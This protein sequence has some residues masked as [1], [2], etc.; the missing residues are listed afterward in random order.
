MRPLRLPTLPSILVVSFAAGAAGCA[1][2]AEPPG[3]LD[4]IAFDSTCPDTGCG[5]N[6]SFVNGWAIGELH[7]GAPPWPPPA[8][9]YDEGLKQSN[10]ANDA[11]VRLLHLRKDG[12]FYR[13]HVEGHRLVGRN[14]AGVDAL[15]GPALEGSALAVKLPDGD[16]A[17][18]HLVEFRRDLP[19]WISPDPNPSIEAFRIRWSY[20]PS[21]DP[22]S[23]TD[24]C[25]PAS[26]DEE[27]DETFYYATFFR[28]DRYDEATKRVIATGDDAG[29]WFNVACF[30]SV[31]SKM[32]FNRHADAGAKTGYE[33]TLDQKDAFLKMLTADFCGWG[34][35]FTETGTKLDWTNSLGWQKL[36]MKA[37]SISYEAVWGPDGALCLDNARLDNEDLI[38]RACELPECAK[39][40][41]RFPTRWDQE[42]YLLSANP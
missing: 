40:I 26:G 25:P 1:L 19:F 20:S 32:L 15:S 4:E 12:Q 31:A 21:Y 34:E 36:R 11:G 13:A 28:G 35:S 17:F 7:E 3:A 30:K 41:E 39:I 2:E 10:K 6:G 9:P 23:A 24:V 42:G 5:T 27:G 37:P 33:A 8:M 18:A 29:A 16:V 22:S 38:R 14:A